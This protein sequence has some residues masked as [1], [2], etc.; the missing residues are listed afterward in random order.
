[1]HETKN[2]VFRCAALSLLMLSANGIL[3]AQSTFNVFPQVADGRFGDGTSYRSTLMILPWFEGDS[4]TCTLTL[5]GMSAVFTGGGASSTFTVNI[6]AGGSAAVQTT[7]AQSYQGGYGTLNCTAAVFANV[8]YT[9]Y[10][11]SGGKI[12]EATVFPSAESV[13][14]RLIADHRD[15]SRLGIAIA[16]NNDSDRTFLVTYVTGSTTLSATIAVPA[17]RSLAKFLDEVISVPAGSVGVVTVTSPTLT[18]FSVIGL[19]Y[20]GGVFTTIP[21]S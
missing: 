18:N 13:K 16:N 9:F 6:P 14:S 12:G 20:T 2:F 8:L 11:S 3:C 10:A 4:P 7:G 19:R 15:G 1:M 17:R 5:Y 21:G